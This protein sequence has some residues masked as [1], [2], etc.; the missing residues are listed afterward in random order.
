MNNNTDK[1]LSQWL[2]EQP[3][4]LPARDGFDAIM[5][6]VHSQ[7]RRR[8]FRI[9]AV[10]AAIFAVILLSQLPKLTTE[11]NHSEQFQQLALLNTKITQ[12]ESVVRGA[13]IQHSSPGS[14]ILEK[15]ISMENWLD[16]LNQNIAQTDDPNHKLELMHAKLEILD[17]LVAL[18]RKMQSPVNQQVI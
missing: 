9:P 14:H 18:Q 2:Q 7:K 16:Q 17:D 10:A 5:D 4:M 11:L 1:H 6:Q 12:I 3:Q 8:S 15:M 13:V